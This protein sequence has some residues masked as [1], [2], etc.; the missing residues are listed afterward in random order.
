MEKKI[1]K[2]KICDKP[3]QILTPKGGGGS[4]RNHWKKSNPP[5]LQRSP[6]I[7][8]TKL[9]QSFKSQRNTLRRKGLILPCIIVRCYNTD[10]W[11]YQCSSKHDKISNSLLLVN[12]PYWR[13][14]KKTKYEYLCIKYSVHSLQIFSAFFANKHTCNTIRYI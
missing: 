6:Q 5:S 10:G 2:L 3:C 1:S 4:T 8:T 14:I 9:K 12:N 11:Y 7:N 13:Y